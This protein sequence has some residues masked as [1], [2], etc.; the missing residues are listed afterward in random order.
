MA[1][2]W[3]GRFEGDPDKGLFDF[4]SSFRFDRRLFADDVTGSA[5][6]AEALHRAGVLTADDTTAIVRALEEMHAR[7]GDRTFFET[8]ARGER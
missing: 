3:S 7:S 6:W 5:A 1:H 2:L 4:G 8:E